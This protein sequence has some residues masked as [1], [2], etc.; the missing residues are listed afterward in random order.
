MLSNLIKQNKK[1]SFQ[2]SLVTLKLESTSKVKPS[3]K[4]FS[5]GPPLDPIYEHKYI[6]PLLRSLQQMCYKFMVTCVRLQKKE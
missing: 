5:F 3:R 2:A 6:F 4:E 1:N